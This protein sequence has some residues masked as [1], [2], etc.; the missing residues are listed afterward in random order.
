MA[1]SQ[2]TVLTSI[3]T[4]IAAVTGVERV[5]CAASSD[6]HALPS[7]MNEFPSIAVIPGET[8]EYILR[9]GQHRH[10]Y[11]VKAL[12]FCNAGGDV[13]QTAAQAVPL[14]DAIIEKFAVNVG[15]SWANSC[16]FERCSG[17][18]TLE[19]AGIDYLGWEITLRVSEQADATPAKGA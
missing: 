10:S 2:S 12:V 1:L 18:V 6:E 3:R 15:G 19:Y 11:D 16:V 17:L 4:L 5:F 7:A 8:V 13:G 14:V 9:S